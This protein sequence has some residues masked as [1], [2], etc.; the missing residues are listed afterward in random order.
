MGRRARLKYTIYLLFSVGVTVGVLTYLFSQVHPAEVLRMGMG[1]RREGLIA[2]LACSLAMSICRL[3]RYE[4]LLR[5]SGFNPPRFSLFLVVL[6]RNFF[7]DLLPARLGTAIY[8]Y[9]VTTR[10]GVTFSAAASSFAASLLL[11]ILAMA[12]LVALAVW[13]LG[14]AVAG[15]AA[16]LWAGVL[17]LA[18]VTVSAWALLPHA[19][20]WAARCMLA[21]SGLRRRA[22]ARGLLMAALGIRRELGRIRTAGIYG[23]VFVLSLLIRIGKYAG[24]YFLLWALLAPKGY[25]FAQLPPAKVF[26]GLTAAELAA[27]TPVSGVAAIGAYEGAWAMAFQLLGFPVDIA[28][29]SSLAHH[30]I[31]QLF[32]YGVGLLAMLLLLLP[33]LAVASPQAVPAA[34]PGRE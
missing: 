25:G 33:R 17:M 8:V 12:P 22:W 27:S 7:S 26:M 20:G 30:A 11:D 34:G 15:G 10:L 2:F 16:A 4:I 3:W 5:V 18:V 28:Q 24:M 21:R 6:V 13:L 32:G 14:G 19:L 29:L 23:R 1:L 31:T 9:L